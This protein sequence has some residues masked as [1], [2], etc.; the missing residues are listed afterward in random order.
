MEL[1][2]KVTELERFYKAVVGRELK[3]RELKQEL[4]KLKK[5]TKVKT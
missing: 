2:E 3:M 1:Q 5:K 4:E